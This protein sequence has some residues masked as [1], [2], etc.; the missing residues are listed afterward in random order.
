MASA[1]FVPK[2]IQALYGKVTCGYV[3]WQVNLVVVAVAVVASLSIN[4][5]TSVDV[6]VVA[7]AVIARPSV[8]TRTSVDIRVDIGV[9]YQAGVDACP[10]PA[11]RSDIGAG[12][13]P[14]IGLARY[15]A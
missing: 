2:D 7:V 3:P 1:L 8:N 13:G 4:T 9:E 5:R 14:G 6:V 11:H 15:R 12:I 10:S